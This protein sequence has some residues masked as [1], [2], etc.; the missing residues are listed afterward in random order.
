MVEEPA[1]QREVGDNLKIR[2]QDFTVVAWGIGGPA[3]SAEE[4]EERDLPVPG[5]EENIF[6]G[7]ADNR[8]AG[9]REEIAGNFDIT[10]L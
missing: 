7:F 9:N 1:E 4:V 10:T 6:W 3:M 2:E 5:R 8:R